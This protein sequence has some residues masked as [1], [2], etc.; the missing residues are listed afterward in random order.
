MHW[1]LIPSNPQYFDREFEHNVIPN[2]QAINWRMSRLKHL[3]PELTG[4]VLDLGCGLGLL[5]GFTQ[6]TYVGVDWSKVAIQYATSHFPHG[7]FIQADI[8]EFVSSVE[9]ASFDTVVLSEVL[10]H[11]HEGD[12]STLLAATKRI[13]RCKVIITV[14]HNSPDPTHVNPQ[15]KCQDVERLIGPA[16]IMNIRGHWMAI[17]ERGGRS[18][19]PGKKP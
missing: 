2:Q 16:E 12:R 17:W 18:T 7:K 15:W 13:T 5:A 3:G 19:K 8:L 14:P 4:S 6:D 11:F 1:P 10:E 9:D